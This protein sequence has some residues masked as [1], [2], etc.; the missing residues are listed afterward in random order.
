MAE[1]LK[2]LLA[3]LRL[4][5]EVKGADAEA[6]KA[7]LKRA[8]K[9]LRGAL[10]CIDNH[11][12]VSGAGPCDCDQ[13]IAAREFLSPIVVHGETCAAKGSREP[14]HPLCTCRSLLGAE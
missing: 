9:V 14:V 2:K 13:A 8:A 11:Y 6:E 3:L 10:Y 5:R 1:K 7:G 12:G 4:Y